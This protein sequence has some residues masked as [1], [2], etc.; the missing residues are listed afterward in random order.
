MA[1]EGW[2][3]SAMVA[4]YTRDAKEANAQLEAARLRLK[5]AKSP[6]SRRR[7]WG[8]PASV[9]QRDQSSGHD[10]QSL[11]SRLNRLPLELEFPPRS[12]G[13]RASNQ[14]I[15]KRGAWA[16]AVGDS[17]SRPHCSHFFEGEPFELVCLPD[18]G[19]GGELRTKLKDSG[20]VLLG[21]APSLGLL[22]LPEALLF[23][24]APL[25]LLLAAGP[26]RFQLRFPLRL[27]LAQMVLMLAI[28][29]LEARSLSGG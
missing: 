14:G 11:V 15:G 27:P 9:S 18:L 25:L 7:W 3:S 13:E 12:V 19:G 5:D 8:V 1:N 22:L 20:F 24:L 17:R 16:F 26:I 2:T 4:R 21:L 10:P 28:F 6:L 29:T 23:F